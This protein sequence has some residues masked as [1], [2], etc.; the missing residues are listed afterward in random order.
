MHMNFSIEAL[1]ESPRCEMEFLSFFGSI[2]VEIDRGQPRTWGLIAGAEGLGCEFELDTDRVLR[3]IKLELAPYTCVDVAPMSMLQ[4]LCTSI[5]ADARPGLV[6]MIQVPT[7]AINPDAVWLLSPFG[8]AIFSFDQMLISPAEQFHAAR[9][10]MEMVRVAEGVTLGLARDT[11]KL[12]MLLLED[13]SRCQQL[14]GIQVSAGRLGKEFMQVLNAIHSAYYEDLGVRAF[15]ARAKKL[16]SRLT[17]IAGLPH[18]EWESAINA[19]HQ[20]VDSYR[21]SLE[22]MI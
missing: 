19:V 21:S 22:E 6:R 8:S 12:R 20:L 10:A 15:D 7:T 18:K 3:A 17:P 4:P 13:F 5:Q 1:S 11:G 9:Q 2:Y 16:V 14:F